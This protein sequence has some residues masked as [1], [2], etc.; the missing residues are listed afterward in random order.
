MCAYTTR[1]RR[2]PTN[3]I[4]INVCVYILAG[5]CSDQSVFIGA[6][7]ACVCVCA[8]GS[9]TTARDRLLRNRPRVRYT[10]CPGN[11]EKVFELE[12]ACAYNRERDGLCIYVFP[13]KIA[14]FASAYVES[15]SHGCSMS[16]FMRGTN[17]FRIENLDLDDRNQMYVYEEDCTCLISP[18]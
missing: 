18:Y 2:M 12:C 13:M 8:R 4:Y 6:A 10:I 15:V 14:A 17:Y 16:I 9:A 11:S 3:Y 7:A 5:D 1:S